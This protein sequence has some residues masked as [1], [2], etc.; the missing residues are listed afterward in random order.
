MA[1]SDSLTQ[2]KIVAFLATRAGS[3]EDPTGRGL[4]A[5]LAEAIGHQRPAALNVLLGQM[6]DDGVI[7]RDVRGLRTYRIAL[8]DDR[9][10]EV[11]AT[12]LRVR[13]TRV[14]AT[15]RS[16]RD[17]ITD[18]S[19][20]PGSNG[21]GSTV[22]W[23]SLAD[24]PPARDHAAP[25]TNGTRNRRLDPDLPQTVDRSDA[26]RHL[27]S[28]GPAVARTR[29]PARNT[30]PAAAE[31]AAA[32]APAAGGRTDSWRDIDPADSW[33]NIGS[34]VPAGA[35][36]GDSRRIA[37][38]DSITDRFSALASAPPAAEESD[39][40]SS[41]RVSS[42]QRST[43]TR[44]HWWDIQIPHLRTAPSNTIL[45]IVGVTM[46]ILV[47]TTVIAVF[48][49]SGGGPTTVA[50]NANSTIDSCTLVTSPEVSVAFKSAAQDPHQVLGA[51]VFDN[52][53]HQLIVDAA[54]NRAKTRFDAAKGD[55]ALD[56]PGLG[57]SAYYTNGRL[58]V[59][60]GSRM[61]LITLVPFSP[62]APNPAL[63]TLAKSVV[64]RL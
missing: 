36:T 3:I 11:P 24:E 59:L 28:A 39:D 43:P 17:S 7:I 26:W 30:E 22:D 38:S 13:P 25:R 60:K 52:G 49:S 33:R 64:A 2:E 53:S 57:D 5:E 32:D 51:C 37:G 44:R 14:G 9:P 63:I 29:G 18:P 56:V 20:P 31:P 58:G 8:T 35:A 6:E 4:T 1:D 41:A 54:D 61:V 19:T 45:A 62:T 23:R 12:L 40:R 34:A 15:N 46:A 16:L 48:T 47:I 50:D 10:A 55:S 27:D 42:P 21:T